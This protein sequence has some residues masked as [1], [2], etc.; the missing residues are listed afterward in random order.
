MFWQVSKLILRMWRNRLKILLWKYP[1]LWACAVVLPLIYVGGAYLLHAVVYRVLADITVNTPAVPNTAQI[2]SFSSFSSFG[3][4]AFL[5]LMVASL[6]S[7]DDTIFSRV[8]APLPMTPHQRYIGV[9][10]PGI[11]FLLI[12]Q[13]LLWGPVFSAFARTLPISV[14]QLVVGVL[15]G[16]L[17]Y[18]TI[19]AL[20][21]Q[22][23]LYNVTR[24]FGA[25]RLGLKSSAL[26]LVIIL[27]VSA[28][29][30]AMVFGGTA[31]LNGQQAWWLWIIPAFWMS[32]VVSAPARDALIGGLLLSSISL[33][34]IIAH[35]RLLNRTARLA[36]GARGG[37]T[38][39]RWLSFGKSAWSACWVY[40][41]KSASRDQQVILGVALI[42]G[43][44]LTIGGVL[45]WL[46][47]SPVAF[48]TPLI[49][50]LTASF[51]ALFVCTIAHMSWGRD[52]EHHRILASMPLRSDVFLAGKIG[53]NIVGLSSLWLVCMAIL[54][55]IERS[56]APLTEAWLL[57]LGVMLAFVFGIIVPFS[58]QDPLSMLVAISIFL[59][60]G[61]PVQFLLQEMGSYLRQPMA[62]SPSTV[63]V[64]SWALYATGLVVCYVVALWMDKMR[65]RERYA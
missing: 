56:F 34:S 57:P 2:I 53:A 5:L 4:T 16:L 47:V 28:L 18:T 43:I 13:L 54:A 1:A 38:P 48:P 33:L 14:A 17:C 20:L 10:L 22:A 61:L 6:F 50:Q 65:E 12:A 51:S 27:G 44:F 60:F 36:D 39:L 30:A 15:L 29:M 64:L 49:V 46:H 21:Y 19:T 25:S 8:F 3:L 37:W 52:Q 23:T 32:L 40:E 59:V 42:V 45:V 55:L 41:W 7:P 58:L 62:L 9:L 26:P 24:A 63:S 31:L 35:R 11:G